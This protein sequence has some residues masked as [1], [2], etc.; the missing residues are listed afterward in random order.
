MNVFIIFSALLMLH[1]IYNKKI[2]GDDERFIYYPYQFKE[3]ISSERIIYLHNIKNKI[4][5]L[6]S[7]DISVLRKLH[8]IDDKLSEAPF[9]ILGGGL[10]DEW[11]FDFPIE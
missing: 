6:T 4:D 7:K 1:Q 8:E 3:N 5:L 10:L 11:N 9:N 2:L